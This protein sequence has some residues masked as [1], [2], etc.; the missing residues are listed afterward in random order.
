MFI[1]CKQYCLRYY[2][3]VRLVLDT[4]VIHLAGRLFTP[5]FWSRLNYCWVPHKANSLHTLT[6][7]P[8]FR[9]SACTFC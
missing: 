5:E 9:S 1:K 3:F 8:I 7:Y 4:A 2:E 6:S